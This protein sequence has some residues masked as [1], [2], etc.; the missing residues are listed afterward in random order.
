MMRLCTSAITRSWLVGVWLLGAG[1]G[2][3]HITDHHRDCGRDCGERV[4]RTYELADFDAIESHSAFR[5]TVRQAPTFR[6]A[7]T[8]PE[9]AVDD[10]RVRREGSQ[11][12]FSLEHGLLDG[13]AH[14]V[15]ELPVLRRLEAYDASRVV[16][17]GLSSTGLVELK[18][19]AASRIEG[20]LAA[21]SLNLELEAA[22]RA[23][24][25]GSVVGLRLE[26]SGLSEARLR[27]LSSRRA[28]VELSGASTAT[29]RVSE[30]LDVEASGLSVLRYV[31][32]PRLGR[33]ELSGGARLDHD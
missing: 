12:R 27:G 26:A 19:R 24:L 16:L 29:I 6:V 15:V 4:T 13:E 20:D 8:V 23:E 9:R 1:C 21:E 25:S 3:D 14:A 17:E 18:L 31:G 2:I 5:L 10:V 22:S 28:G 11:L 33:I 7:V 30:W 32:D